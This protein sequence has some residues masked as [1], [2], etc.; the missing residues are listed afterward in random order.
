MIMET[1]NEEYGLGG[2]LGPDNVTSGKRLTRWT[3]LE[4]GLSKYPVEHDTKSLGS[5]LTVLRA[6]F[7]DELWWATN[8]ARLPNS[9]AKMGEREISKKIDDRLFQD[10]LDQMPKIERDPLS[11]DVAGL[12]KPRPV[13]APTLGK[14]K[15]RTAIDI[16]K[17]KNVQGYLRR[18]VLKIGK[19]LKG[20]KSILAFAHSDPKP[21]MAQVLATPVE[22]PQEQ[23][24]RFATLQDE[25]ELLGD[26]TDDQIVTEEVVMGSPKRRKVVDMKSMLKEAEVIS[27]HIPDTKPNTYVDIPLPSFGKA[28]AMRDKKS[29]RAYVA[30]TYYLKCKHF[31]HI[32]DP[33]F[34]RTL[35]QDA[36]AWMIKSEFKMET[37]AE[38][39]IL[40]SAVAAAFFVDQEELSFR[41]RMKN[42]RNWQ[43]IEKHNNAC[44][45]DLGY[46]FLGVEA[47]FK[48]L[49]HLGKTH[50]HLPLT[51][52]SP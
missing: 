1:I 37:Y 3:S 32:K 26:G 16:Q 11:T 10:G 7:R 42:A 35:V 13:V 49:R 2:V 48:T 12:P 39:C 8:M 30:L 43:A 23:P 52:P 6:P 36:R 27:D 50:V 45:G 21:R 24:N 38:Y 28:R 17:E 5:E 14:Y 18:K 15:P 31:M 34:I 40:A 46:R 19:V 47:R 51:Q 44:N 20:A 29:R 22:H 33:H 9:D 25:A 4:D 41:A